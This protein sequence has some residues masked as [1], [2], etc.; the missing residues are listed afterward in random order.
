MAK[1]TRRGAAE[2]RR[3]LNAL[4]AATEFISV[5]EYVC[6]MCDYIWYRP[7]VGIPIPRCPTHT[8]FLEVVGRA[9]GPERQVVQFQAFPARLSSNQSS[10]NFAPSSISNP[11]SIVNTAPQAEQ[12]P[13]VG[14]VNNPQIPGFADTL[15]QILWA[16]STEITDCP[17]ICTI[18]SKRRSGI[19]QIFFGRRVYQLVLWCEH[20]GYWHPLPTASYYISLPRELIPD[21]SGK[22]MI[23][24]GE[25]WRILRALLFKHDQLR[26]FGGMRRVLA[27][28]GDFLWV[29]ANHY[30]EYDPGLPVVP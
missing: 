4:P 3:R 21:S 11:G 29:C 14:A 5:Q 25:N 10:A 13:S 27:S 7:S 15:S 18:A 6:P 20:P 8:V 22:L 24:E 26:S 28:S 2:R 9:V 23:M 30:S 12:A 1:A 16:L 19:R 17:H